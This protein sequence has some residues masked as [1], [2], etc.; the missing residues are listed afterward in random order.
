MNGYKEKN[1]YYPKGKIS[2]GSK[3][4]KLLLPYF[5]TYTPDEGRGGLKRFNPFYN[6]SPLRL[7]YYK[8]DGKEFEFELKLLELKKKEV[9]K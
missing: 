9:S 8:S 2:D 3:F 5:P 7:N 4:Y 6:D 1:G